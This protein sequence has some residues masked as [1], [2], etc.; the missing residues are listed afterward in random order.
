MINLLTSERSVVWSWFDKRILSGEDIGVS[1]VYSEQRQGRDPYLIE[2]P[3]ASSL[4]QYWSTVRVVTPDDKQLL[5]DILTLMRPVGERL[6]IIYLNLLDRFNVQDDLTQ[7]D[8]F[9]SV[10]VTVENGSLNLIDSASLQGVTCK[11]SNATTWEHY[12]ISARVR[13][14]ESVSDTVWFGVMFYIEPTAING[15]FASIS[16]KDNKLYF[17]RLDSSVPTIEASFDFHSVGYALQADVWYGL[18]VECIP[19]TTATRF[20]IHMN[21][22]ERINTTHST[23]EE[24]TVGVI[25]NIDATCQC[26]EIEVLALPVDSETLEPI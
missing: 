14:S 15:Y 10:Q 16:I 23:Y 4:P 8:R 5:R 13:G 25:H 9:G 7:W 24:G 21:G 2:M 3:S 18:R 26:D 1:T 6:E 19:G 17:G 20:R 22:V 12:V 11:V